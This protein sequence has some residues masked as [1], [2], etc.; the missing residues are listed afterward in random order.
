MSSKYSNQLSYASVNGCYYNIQK[1]KNQVEYEI[2]TNKIFQVMYFAPATTFTV[3]GYRD[4]IE[5]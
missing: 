1:E 4:K 5:F 3:G 2:F